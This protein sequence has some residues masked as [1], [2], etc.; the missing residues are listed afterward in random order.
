MWSLGFFLKAQKPFPE[1][2]PKAFQMLEASGKD[3]A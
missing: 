1:P 3:F 2:P